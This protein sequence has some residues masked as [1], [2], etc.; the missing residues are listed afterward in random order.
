MTANEQTTNKDP[1]DVA[2]DEVVDDL[3]RS[4]NENPHR[5]FHIITAKELANMF[6]KSAA[7]AEGLNKADNIDQLKIQQTYGEQL[8]GYDPTELYT[9]GLKQLLKNFA[10]AVDTLSYCKGTTPPAIRATETAI[11]HIQTACFWAQN[12]LSVSSASQKVL[13]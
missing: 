3:L 5:D 4:I 1:L 6:T 2:I 11:S 8:I 7:R 12:A 13:V 9:P 10:S